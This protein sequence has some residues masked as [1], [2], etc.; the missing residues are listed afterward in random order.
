MR[1]FVLL[2]V[3]MQSIQFKQTGNY[4]GNSDEVFAKLGGT[5]TYSGSGRG[6]NLVIQKTYERDNKCFPLQFEDWIVDINGVI[7][8][9]NDEQYQALLSIKRPMSLGEAIALHVREAIKKEQSQGGLLARNQST[10]DIEACR[11]RHNQKDY[12]PFMGKLD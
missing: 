2:G 1:G 7:L 3:S 4:V 10:T 6:E 11:K 8:V 5:I 9:L 12:G